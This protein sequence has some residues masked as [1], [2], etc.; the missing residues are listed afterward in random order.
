MTEQDREKINEYVADA[1]ALDAGERDAFLL[2]AEMTELQ[3]AEAR[4]LLSMADGAASMLDAPAIEFSKDFFFADERERLA[5]RAVGPFT[6]IRE[7]GHGGMGAVYLA[8]RKVGERQQR[9][10]LKLLKR[11]MN[12]SVFRQRFEQ[13]RAILATLSHP[14]ISSLV[15]FGSTDDGTPYFAMEYVDGHPIDVFCSQNS[16]GCDD[17]LALFQKVCSA[18]SSAHRGLV[19]HRDLKPSNILVTSDG[20]PKLLD[21]GI[22]KILSD[23]GE[24]DQTA[25]VTRLG[26]MTPSYASPEQLNGESV[27]TATDIYSLGVILFELLSGHRPFEDKEKDLNR[28]LRAV[29]EDEP[30]PPSSKAD[31]G[32]IAEKRVPISSSRDRAD[33]ARTLANP[34]RADTGREDLREK[35]PRSALRPQEIRGD[36]DRIVLKSLQKEPERRYLSVDA[37]SD[38]IGRFREGRPVT[39]R[40]ATLLYRSGKFLRRNRA[41]ALVGALL[42]IAVAAGI[43]ATLWQARIA[44]AERARA[45]RRFED[46]RALA[47][48]FLF[49]ITPD[50]ERL[51]GSTPAK[52]KLVTRALEYLNKL[53]L[54]S[55]SDPELM[56]EIARAYDKVGDVQGN[57]S[58]PNIGDIK[59]ALSSYQKALDIRLALAERSPNDIELMS[60]IADDY[61]MLGTLESFG[62]DYAKATPLLDRSLE[63]R[64]QVLAADADNFVFR[65][66]Y[67]STIRARGL[68]PFYDGDNR[69]AIEYFK[70]SQ[71]LYGSL[72][73]QQPENDDVAA[74]YYYLF[75]NIGEAQGWENEL[76]AALEK[77]QIGVDGLK[78]IAARHPADRS[79]QRTLHLAY[80]R[81]GTAFEDLEKFGLGIDAYSTALAIAKT[82]SESDPTDQT[83][84]R[85]VALAY[86]KLGQCQEGAGKLADS[87]RSIQNAIAVFTEL[88]EA[89][90]NNFE[91]LYDV[92]NTTFSLGMTYA[93]MKNY[94]EA[95]NTYGRSLD[96]FKNVIAANPTNTYAR[97]MTAHN[98]KC[99]AEALAA[100]RVDNAKIAENYRLSLEAFQALA[101]EDKLE[102]I[103][104]PVIP[105]IEGA[106][107]KL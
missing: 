54:D 96:K 40:S 102:K 101:S 28:I 70:R 93:S 71:A 51:P 14:N 25:T 75:V 81:L 57:P 13:E 64:E 76:D 67:A 100:S 19:V 72:L 107:S 26:A 86:K 48:S 47:N 87:L 38:D 23:S 45:E 21:F 27:T 97:R 15:D 104:E 95:I 49:E 90:P 60:G 106:L 105:E 69:S 46:V 10:A 22:S 78:Q 88:S 65:N 63:L 82:S 44:E 41:M 24:Q 91:V 62:G 9:V 103:D 18:V 84:K 92:A 61:H 3:L 55:N 1:L 56:R 11:E 66:K 12:S 43:F 39:A 98:Y 99:L 80:S 34:L 59:G 42:V 52:V 50:I 32:E 58:A 53:T 83:A 89:D 29:A 8:S 94:P 6:I 20:T 17:R 68:I 35:T 2:R 37:F 30:P 74:D 33:E 77:V 36:L 73:K 16:Y 4:S 5:G 31:S 85:D 79:F 7:V